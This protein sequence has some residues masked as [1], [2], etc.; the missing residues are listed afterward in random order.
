M[1]AEQAVESGDLVDLTAE[2]DELEAEQAVE[3]G[4]RVDLTDSGSVLIELRMD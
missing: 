3:A 4:E 1:G 2:A